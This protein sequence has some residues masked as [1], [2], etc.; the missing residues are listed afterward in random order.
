MWVIPARRRSGLQA[1]ALGLIR[2]ARLPQ[3]LEE[4]RFDR[5]RRW[6]F[7]FAWPE[8]RVAVEVDGETAHARYHQT[9]RDALKRNAAQVQGWRVLVWTGSLIRQQ[10][11]A[12]LD[13]LR[14]LL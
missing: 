13:Q 4:Y 14:L 5:Q 6:R 3:P 10:P 11:A 1:E 9:S 2:W 7:D 12:L 8:Q